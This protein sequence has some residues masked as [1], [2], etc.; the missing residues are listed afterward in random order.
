MLKICAACV[1]TI[2]DARF[3]SCIK[4]INV[5]DDTT[6]PASLFSIQTRDGSCQSIFTWKTEK[7]Q[8]F[9]C[10]N[11]KLCT[12]AIKMYKHTNLSM[13]NPAMNPHFYLGCWK[14]DFQ[15]PFS[16]HQVMTNSCHQLFAPQNSDFWVNWGVHILALMT[17]WPSERCHS[18]G[19]GVLFQLVAVEKKSL[20]EVRGPKMQLKK[21]GSQ[22][23][24]LM[25]Q[26]N[27]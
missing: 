7:N 20:F 3:Q 23:H 16:C 27:G 19:L 2:V 4:K 6:N 17:R 18:K 12:I 22:C 5:N 25:T 14:H 9:N 13:L 10:D 21:S 26:I 11:G 15:K 1:L 8:F 24:Q